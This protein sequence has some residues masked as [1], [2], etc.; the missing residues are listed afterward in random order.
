MNQ[1]EVF[2]I[3]DDGASVSEFLS[4]EV[5]NVAP[6]IGEMIFSVDG[7]P[8]LPDENGTWTIDE[9]IVATLE[10]DA[11]DTLSDKEGLLVTWYPDSS[12]ENWTITTSGPSSQ[13]TASWGTSGLHEIKAFAIDDDGE[14]SFDV[15][16]YV[17]VNNI[18]YF[19]LSSC[20]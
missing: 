9:D 10:T 3:D 20:F 13:I 14:T 2:V 18:K 19:S 1:I 16:G 7:I 15:I 5:L 12:D 11:D 17:N 4:Y 6:T 8:Y